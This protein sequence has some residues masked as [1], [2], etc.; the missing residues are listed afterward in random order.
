MRRVVSP[1]ALQLAGEAVH[2]KVPEELVAAPE[3]T[4]AQPALL[5]ALGPFSARRGCHEG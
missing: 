2:L 5:L 3:G 1:C 4:V